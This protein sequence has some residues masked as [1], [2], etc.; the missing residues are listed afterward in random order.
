[1]EFDKSNMLGVI[2]D[3]PNQ[4]AKGFELAEGIQF[5]GVENIVVAGMGGSASYA[6]LLKAYLTELKLPLVVHRNY[7]L[8]R[9]V[10]RYTL[11]VASSYS[12]NTEEPLDAFEQ[13]I[14]IAKVVGIAS[15]GKLKELCAKHNFPLVLLPQGIQPRS[16]TGYMFS[17]LLGI[18]ENSG[19][20][21]NKKKEV[22]AMAA[23][24]S[25]NKAKLKTEGEKLAKAAVGKIPIIYSSEEFGPVARMCKIKFN[26]NTKVAS[27]YNVFPE[28]N[29]HEMNGTRYI[30]MLHFFFIEKPDDHPQIQKRMKVTKKLLEKRG[31]SV[32]EI[33]PL[34][35][36]K[37]ERMFNALYLFDWTSFFLA[38]Q[39]GIDPTPVE[40]VEELKKEL[41]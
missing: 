25:R 24:L 21:E 28:L 18:L 20:V 10:G 17:A 35:K 6:D 1:M 9:G 32:T 5:E 31:G 40:L 34:G 16:S 3:F 38:M 7:G 29:H 26:E 15:G 19:I 12:G 11:F 27:F 33:I 41:K 2:D 14:K 13:A 37:L 8:P 4:F 23:E 22:L 30:D 36:T 39:Y